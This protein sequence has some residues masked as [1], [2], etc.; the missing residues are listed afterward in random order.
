ML[1]VLLL[2]LGL[3]VVP[4]LRSPFG[5]A[6]GWSMLLVLLGAAT[7]DAAAAA[8]LLRRQKPGTG[9]LGRAGLLGLWEFRPKRPFARECADTTALQAGL[10]MSH[11]QLLDTLGVASTH[12]RTPSRQDA[13]AD[14]RLPVMLLLDCR[15]QAPGQESPAPENNE[16]ATAC[17]WFSLLALR[18]GAAVGCAT[19]A[20]PQPRY[21][22]PRPGMQQF[23]TLLDGLHDLPRGSPSDDF[24]TD[25]AHILA[26]QQQRALIILV[27]TLESSTALGIP[28]AL[29]GLQLQ[30]H[31]LLVSLTHDAA[32][33]GHLKPVTHLHGALLYCRRVEQRA[34]REAL[35]T[36][37]RGQGVDVLQS[38]G[39]DLAQGLATRYLE[40]RDA[41]HV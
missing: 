25:L 14:A 21:V 20:S 22:T 33:P 8:G 27:T 5:T 12:L 18:Q 11:T 28:S 34:A 9:L 3:A 16:A 26:R 4:T 41:G 23:N 32:K 1:A 6:I 13:P 29:A 24:H 15:A 31:L 2:S 36:Q 38:R 30:H 40:L 7:L 19:L 39:S 37:L 10:L 17:L 35:H